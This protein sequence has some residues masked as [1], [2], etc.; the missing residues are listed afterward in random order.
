MH[1]APHRYTTTAI[2]LHWLL[3][4]AIFMS[5]VVGNFM[6]DLPVSPLRLRLAN[7]HKWA[8]VTILALGRVRPERGP[9]SDPGC[10]AGRDRR[11]RREGARRTPTP[12]HA[13]R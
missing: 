8:G 7:W 12:C 6:S 2:V 9:G 5:L 1:D 10:D 11:H 13:A 3:A 4:V